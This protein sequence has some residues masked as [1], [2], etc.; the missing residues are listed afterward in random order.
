MGL[1][2]A[3]KIDFVRYFF[4]VA[5]FYRFLSVLPGFGE[6]LGRIWEGLGRVW[7]GFSFD[8][9]LQNDIWGSEW[10]WD[11]RKVCGNICLK[12]WPDVPQ[13]LGEIF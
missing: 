1:F 3:S 5:I 6:G 10:G 12:C 9:G 4:E 7:E 13:C 8:F 11:V 2:L